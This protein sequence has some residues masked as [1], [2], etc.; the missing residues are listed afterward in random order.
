MELK[1]LDCVAQ[2][3]SF[4][5][6]QN[7][8]NTPEDYPAPVIKDAVTLVPAWQQQVFGGQ[9]VMACVAVPTCMDHIQVSEMTAEQKAVLGGRLL[10]GT[11]GQS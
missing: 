3:K 10:Q 6:N 1:C 5:A 2:Y 9:I 4:L 8:G 7:L 11:V